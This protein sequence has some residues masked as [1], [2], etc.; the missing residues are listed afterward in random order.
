M[1]LARKVAV[2]SGASAGIGAAIA[3]ELSKR[4]ATVAINY[5][6][7]S[8]KG[9]AE[10]VLRSLGP[11]ATAITVE[12]DL[13][14]YEG[15]KVL[16]KTV[17]D[18]FGH[19][20]ILVNNAGVVLPVDIGTDTDE[21]VEKVWDSTM[22]L[23]GRGV[24]LLTRAVLKHLRP[25]NSRIINIA[26]AISHSTQPKQDIYGGSKGMVEAFTRFWAKELPRKYGCTVNAVAPGP[27][28]TEALL[29][30]R[31]DILD[32][33]GPILAMTPVASR[34]A[35]PEEIAWTVAM[36]CDEGAGW[37]NGAWIPVTGGIVTN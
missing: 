16:A 19:I 6:W 21:E 7:P 36:L 11:Q 12:A 20:D 26:S 1:S 5:P 25:E 34:L 24:F 8:E 13:S 29:A 15:P 3:R 10:K 31:Q 35:K 17:A 37:I 28:E 9:N 33:I 18:K 2:V 23:N 14:T 4:G 32:D 22:N 27:V 30:A